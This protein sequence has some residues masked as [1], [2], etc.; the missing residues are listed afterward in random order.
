MCEKIVV[1]MKT[2]E[3]SSATVYGQGSSGRIDANVRKTLR[4]RPSNEIIELV[5]E[6]LTGSKAEVEKHFGVNLNE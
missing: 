3:G 1:E 2:G 5:T 6:R 4:V